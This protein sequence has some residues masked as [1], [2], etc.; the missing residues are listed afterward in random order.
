VE[1]AARHAAAGRRARRRG[2]PAARARGAAPARRPRAPVLARGGLSRDGPHRPGAAPAGSGGESRARA[3]ADADAARAA[4]H[5]DRARRGR[6]P[7]ALARR[8]PHEGGGRA[9]VP[10]RARVDQ[11]P[12]GQVGA[13]R[14]A[15]AVSR[16]AARALGTGVL[17]LASFASNAAAAPPPTTVEGTVT[18]KVAPSSEGAVVTLEAPGKK[19]SPPAEVTVDQQGL[20]FLPHL[21][22]VPLGTRVRFLNSDKEPHNVYSPEGRYNLGVWGPGDAREHTFAQAGAYTQL[23]NLHPDMLAFV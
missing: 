21:S 23:C 11:R 1:P 16:L 3:P 13:S 19:G 15:Q 9:V 6:G 22:V 14:G 10:G 2:A 8:G 4:L 20:K 5:A 17:A 18:V 12:D 7:R